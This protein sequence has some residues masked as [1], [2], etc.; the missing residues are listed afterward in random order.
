MKINRLSKKTLMQFAL[1]ILAIFAIRMWQQQD[2]SQ[3]LAPSFESKTLTGA[4]ISSYA[5]DEAT[6]IHFWA[7]WCGI[8][9]IENSNIQ[10]I[11]K[12]YRVLNIALQS[13]TDTELKKYANEHNMRLDNIVNDNSGSLAKL[14]GVRAT[15]SSFFIS[16]HNRIKFI[17]VGYVTTLG[18]RLR[19]W[20][21]NL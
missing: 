6:L 8:C 19:L 7:T 13:G 18:Y 16:K 2:L 9:R 14:F 4:R 21:L 15:P 20:W 5:N 10:S 1:V 11:S 17:E 12:D 3:G